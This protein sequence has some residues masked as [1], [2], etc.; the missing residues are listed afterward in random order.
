LKTVYKIKDVPAGCKLTQAAMGGT[1]AI[2]E[3]RANHLTLKES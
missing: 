2:Y 1:S 3:N